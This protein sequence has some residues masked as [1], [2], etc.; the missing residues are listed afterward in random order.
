[1]ADHD[2][3]GMVVQQI[4]AGLQIMLGDKIQIIARRLGP[5]GEMPFIAGPT[6]R[7]I[8]LGIVIGIRP[9]HL[10]VSHHVVGVWRLLG[11]GARGALG[12]FAE[13][14]QPRALGRHHG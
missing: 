1:M 8:F 6:V 9:F 14:A 10:G 13:S 11:Q 5:A 2:G 4:G 12:Q 7:G 3:A